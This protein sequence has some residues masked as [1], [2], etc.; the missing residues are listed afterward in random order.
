MNFTHLTILISCFLG[1]LIV[2]LLFLVI[3]I[4][5]KT[6]LEVEKSSSYECGFHSFEDTR[7]KFNVRYYLVGI[8][9]L[10]F[11]LEVI[12]IFP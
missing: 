9:F 7:Q 3:N 2:L 8:L 1:L 6:K 10:L 5:I 11:D 4:L 12:L